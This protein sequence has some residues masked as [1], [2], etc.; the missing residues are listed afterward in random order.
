MKLSFEQISEFTT[1]AVRIKELNGE[2]H[3]Y[4]FS[5]AQENLYKERDWDIQIQTFM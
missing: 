4:R 3:L 2:T 1:G 5:E